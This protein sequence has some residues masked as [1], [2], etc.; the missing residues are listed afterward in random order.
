MT[1]RIKNGV[2]VARSSV[3][4]PVTTSVAESPWQFVQPEHQGDDDEELARRDGEERL[5][6]TPAEAT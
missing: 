1:R 4:A 2:H 6:E 3:T 5:G